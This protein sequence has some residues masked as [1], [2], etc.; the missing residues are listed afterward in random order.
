M[1]I[2]HC[3]NPVDSSEL[4]DASEQFGCQHIKLHQPTKNCSKSM[5]SHDKLAEGEGKKKAEM[6]TRRRRSRRRREEGQGREENEEGEEEKKERKEK[7]EKKE[8]GLTLLKF[9]DPHLVGGKTGLKSMHHT[10]T[11]L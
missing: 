3:L 5:S 9:R 7:K 2:T 8:K 11:N 1:G 6:R 10:T 4:S